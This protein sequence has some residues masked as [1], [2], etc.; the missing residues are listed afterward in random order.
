MIA[1]STSRELSITLGKTVWRPLERNLHCSKSCE[2]HK[3]CLT[4]ILST[5]GYSNFGRSLKSPVTACYSFLCIFF[6]HT[7]R[8]PK[9]QL[10]IM[11]W[12]CWSMLKLL[13]FEKS[14]FPVS[15]FLS[16][17]VVM[18]SCFF[19]LGFFCFSAAALVLTQA[20]WNHQPGR[21]LAWPKPI[22]EFSAWLLSWIDSWSQCHTHCKGGCETGRLGAKMGKIR[23]NKPLC[24]LSCV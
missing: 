19:C 1:L 7:I 9:A 23:G 20:T 15:F 11:R 12:A 3:W 18:C 4:S 13:V 14:W 24:Q 10:H 17:P 6:Y 16:L 22:I 2:H 8:Q 5:N 21:K